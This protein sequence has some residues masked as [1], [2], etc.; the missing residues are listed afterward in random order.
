MNRGDLVIVS[1]LPSY[2][3]S[4]DI[5]GNVGIIIELISES[6]YCR[7]LMGSGE[8]PVISLVHLELINDLSACK[9]SRK[10]IPSI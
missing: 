7:V 4:T 6:N 10:K 2:W 1:S 9:A 5:R 3:G 8:T